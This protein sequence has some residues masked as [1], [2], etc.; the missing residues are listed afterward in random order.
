MS[1]REVGRRLLTLF[2][3]AFKRGEGGR[4]SYTLNSFLSVKLISVPSF[5]FSMT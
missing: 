1:E 4:R 2:D 3:G 5:F